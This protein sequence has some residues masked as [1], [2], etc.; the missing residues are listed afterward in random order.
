M[1]PFAL[2]VGAICH[3]VLLKQGR[4]NLA[5]YACAG[6]LA[7]AVI[8]FCLSFTVSLTL[9][10]AIVGGETAAVAWLIRRPDRDIVIPDGPRGVKDYGG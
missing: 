2:G 6:A 4:T 8:A 5:Y 10:G 7:G 9:L 1:A 3:A